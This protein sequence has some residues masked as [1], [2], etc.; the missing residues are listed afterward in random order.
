MP[1]G[2]GGALHACALMRDVGLGRAIVP[3]FPGVTSAMGCIIADMRQ[4][5]VQTVNA[6]TTNVDIDELIALMQAHS[7]QG[8][9]LL[10]DSAVSFAGRQ[11]VFEL[12]MA[13]VGQ[14]HTVSVQLP[15]ALQEGRVAPFER[16]DI[17]AAF[18]DSYRALYGRL[19]PNSTTRILNLR[20]S[21]IGLRPKLD[22]SSLAPR[23]LEPGELPV[24]RTTRRVHV[25]GAWHDTPIYDRLALPTG[26]V[27][28]GPAI[29]EQPDT[30]ILIEPGIAGT[31]DPYGNV[32]LSPGQAE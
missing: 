10:D 17:Q 27:I 11:V 28:E 16:A 18:D 21:V 2:G 12:D 19:L 30:T 31:V 25:G 7:D 9:G 3:R 6:L 29:L 22:L 23:A 20:S 13:Y 15:V 5:F 24:A 26:L 14:T 8:H 4:D 1:F 32:I